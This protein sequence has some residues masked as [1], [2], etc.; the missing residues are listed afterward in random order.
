[1]AEPLAGNLRL[2][3]WSTTKDN[4]MKTRAEL[5]ADIEEK[6]QK[7]KGIEPTPEVMVV[8]EAALGKGYDPYDNPGMRKQ[9]PDGVDVTARRRAM[10]ARKRR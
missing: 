8:A 2:S 9:Q 1:M 7:N 10:F 5:L 3:V 6:R 4:N